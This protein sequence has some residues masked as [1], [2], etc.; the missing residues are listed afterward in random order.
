M[1][2][3]VWSCGEEDIGGSA[4]RDVSIF[5]GSKP[6]RNAVLIWVQLRSRCLVRRALLSLLSRLPAVVVAFYRVRGFP[7]LGGVAVRL[8]WRRARLRTRESRPG[9]LTGS[10]AHVRS[11]ET[12]DGCSR[13]D[14]DGDQVMESVPGPGGYGLVRTKDKKKQQGLVRESPKQSARPIVIR[15]HLEKKN[16]QATDRRVYGASSGPPRFVT[17]DLGTAALQDKTFMAFVATGYHYCCIICR[18]RFGLVPLNVVH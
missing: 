10:G 6:T 15:H 16:L 4:G 1:K 18:S 12:R 8:S 14:L 2:K 11:P 3:A 9:L 13:H 17:C 7:G 5:S